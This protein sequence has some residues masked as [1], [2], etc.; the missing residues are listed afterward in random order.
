LVALS[1]PRDK[2]PRDPSLPTE[3]GLKGGSDETKKLEEEFKRNADEERY[4]KAQQE[5]AR[6]KSQEQRYQE[7]QRA[8][9]RRLS[10]SSGGTSKKQ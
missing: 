1:P 6:K 4:R 8:E 2:W 10:E 9:F 3:H 5:N 7:Q